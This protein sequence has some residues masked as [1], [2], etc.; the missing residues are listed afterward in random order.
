MPR[1]SETPSAE[2]QKEW[3][4]NWAA[5]DRPSGYR[6]TTARYKSLHDRGFSATRELGQEFITRWNVHMARARTGILS[7]QEVRELLADNALLH[8][9]MDKFEKD[10]G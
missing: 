6:S 2:N 9:A 3:R 4:G 10:K 7:A 5:G 1:S 8:E